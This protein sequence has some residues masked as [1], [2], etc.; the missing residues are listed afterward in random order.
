MTIPE[1]FKRPVTYATK[2]AL[3]ITLLVSLI[4]VTEG[5]NYWLTIHEI[6]ETTSQWCAT[7]DLLTKN[8]VPYPANPSANPSRLE[9]YIL[10][11]DFVKLRGEFGCD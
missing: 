8:K 7:L 4:L 3:L 10:F 9:A 2:V 6:R 11:E 1:T 5:L